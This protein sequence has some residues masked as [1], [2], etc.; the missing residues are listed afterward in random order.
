MKNENVQT[1]KVIFKF[2]NNKGFTTVLL[3]VV[4]QIIIFTMFMAL[5]P[6]HNQLNKLAKSN[7]EY[8]VAQIIGEELGA[9][10]AEAYYDG[11]NTYPEPADSVALCE[12]VLGTIPR[13]GT[14]LRLSNPGSA[15]GEFIFMCIPDVGIRLKHPLLS[16]RFVV[17]GER[18]NDG[19]YG[20]TN[21]LR[22]V[23]DL[24]TFA[25]HPKQK[26]GNP[27]VA[28]FLNL[29]SPNAVAQV[30]PNLIPG[31]AKL[32]NRIV[33]TTSAKIIYEPVSPL[34]FNAILLNVRPL[35]GSPFFPG[36]STVENINCRPPN[37]THHCI[38]YKFCTRI[39][40]EASP[41][42]EEEFIWQMVALPKLPRET[43]NSC[44]PA[45]I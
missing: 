10:I 25:V 28:F 30:E 12:G 40:Q 33:A 4:A 19:T 11:F 41:C 42:T 26:T 8:E 36:T 13:R 21:W 7:R 22:L 17:F 6:L 15:N 1:S 3:I 43:A 9:K 35:P 2:N 44:G 24:A 18:R 5:S 29:I 32:P 38:A 20:F 31:I 39:N 34:P 45:L 27:K 23:E 37:N 14:L 16:D